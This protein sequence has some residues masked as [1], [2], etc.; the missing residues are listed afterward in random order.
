MRA[1]VESL[2]D[3]AERSAGAQA[4]QTLTRLLHKYA[5]PADTHDQ[6]TLA[7]SDLPPLHSLRHGAI[8]EATGEF[9]FWLDRQGVY[10]DYS[11]PHGRAT[12]LP[13]DQIIGA[14]I[15][16][17]PMPEADLNAVFAALEAAIDTDALQTVEYKLEVQGTV[18]YF[19]ARIHRSG[20]NEAIAVVS[21][22]TQR[23]EA[24]AALRMSERRLRQIIDL[25][26]HGI[27]VK[28]TD[29]RYLVVNETAARYCHSTVDAMIG[30]SLL[31]LG[32]HPTAVAALHQAD[33]EIARSGVPHFYKEQEFRDL[34]GNLR[35]Y[36]TSIVPC[37][38]DEVGSPAIVGIT[39]DVT[40]QKQ[41]AEALRQ[42]EARQR[43]LLSAL[44]DMM[45]RLTR[46]GTYLDFADPQK[47]SLLPHDRIIGSNI[48]DWSF[49]RDSWH[50]ALAAYGRAIDSGE[51]QTI[52]Y[53][54]PTAPDGPRAYESRIVRSGPNEVV[55]VIRDISERRQVEA[56]IRQLNEELEERVRR[57]TYEL[58]AANRELESFSYSVSHDLRAPLRAISG[59][60]QVLLDE[61]SQQL[62]AEGRH[63][64]QRVCAASQRMAQLIDD[65]LD[66]AR[67]TR[68]VMQ[69]TPINLS[70][71]AH[72][73]ADELRHAQPERCV[74]FVIMPELWV[75]ADADLMRVA[76]GN[77][78]NN[79]WKYTSNHPHARIEFGSH[80]APKEVVYFV[81]DDGAGFDMAHA[82]KL[83]G[84]F[85]RLHRREE[86]EGNGVGLATV[87]RIIHRHG[88]RVWATAAVEQGASFYFT[89]G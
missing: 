48:R 37:T 82:D 51:V 62:D 20:A 69:R 4:L 49:G 22:I 18:T 79:A 44:P 72:T 73:L 58:E 77:L 3:A 71:I 13:P 12:Y 83:F 75:E 38:L 84:A 86:F 59:F 76:L 9:L 34:D 45:F 16:A 7:M 6:P 39:I 88:G 50:L 2:T 17:L 47:Q 26:P 43:A 78:L 67:V 55:A 36:H 68:H 52:E 57:R 15:R 31:D 32:F 5:P 29:G 81:R 74:E 41:V 19:Q 80:R 33:V 87:Q 56:R 89:F 1:F 30:K 70:T 35:V 61:Y 23:K 24:E 14:T 21:D 40:E 46:D 60:S 42:A 25:V 11:I 54:V 28:D 27:Y 53:D 63:Y 64:L 85:Q 8:L 10:L 65:L 66:L